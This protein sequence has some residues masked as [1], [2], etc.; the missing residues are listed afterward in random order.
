M[1][2]RVGT[3]TLTIGRKHFLL[4]LLII[5]RKLTC[6]HRLQ[7]LKTCPVLPPIQKTTLKLVWKYHYNQIKKFNIWLLHNGL[8]FS[9]AYESALLHYFFS[10]SCY[11][12]WNP[13][14]F[15][16]C[17]GNVTDHIL[18]LVL[19]L[20]YSVKIILQ[21]RRSILENNEKATLNITIP[22]FLLPLSRLV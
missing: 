19:A 22:L 4:L 2:W 9:S 14:H 8:R 21:A 6:T 11:S 1:T 7:G 20:H 12:I 13:L 17:I 3:T 10:K 18:I 15:E 5:M 16:H